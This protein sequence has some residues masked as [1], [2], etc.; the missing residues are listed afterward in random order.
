MNASTKYTMI[1]KYN[2]NT[3]NSRMKYKIPSYVKTT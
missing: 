3:K 2:T 1:K